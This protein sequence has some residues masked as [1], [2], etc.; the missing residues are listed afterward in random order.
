MLFVH[1]K[2][3]NSPDIEI[4]F[5]ENDFVENVPGIKQKYFFLPS[6]FKHIHII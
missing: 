4:L 3:I 1:P 5:A 6:H 2:I